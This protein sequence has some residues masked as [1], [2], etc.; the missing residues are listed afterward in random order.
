MKLHLGCGKRFIPGYFHVDAVPFDHVELVH[1]VDHLPMVA[2]ESAKVIYT[3]HVLEH[4]SRKHV[5]DVLAE[6]RRIL[7]P[8]GT[9]RVAVPDFAAL[10]EVYAKTGNLENIIG[11]LFGRGDYL[12]NVHYTVWDFASLTDALMVAGFHGVRRYDWRQT[13]HADVD[14]Y[15]SAYFP[16]MD[17]EH[18]TLLSLNVEATR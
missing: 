13:E 17:K 11:P 14:D 12:Y 6:W 16:H 10:A 5:P 18:G 4:F 7:A 2:D 8:G 1:E 15:A 3:C 9:L